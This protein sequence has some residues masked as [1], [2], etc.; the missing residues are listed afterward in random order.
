MDPRVARIA[1]FFD[2][3]APSYRLCFEDWPQACSLRAR[4]LH[5]LLAP[6][7]LATMA[8][9]DICYGGRME[10]LNAIIAVL[11]KMPNLSVLK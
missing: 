11:P 1:Y 2:D 6:P 7:A 10:V 5:E 8:R 9:D 3:L 4:A